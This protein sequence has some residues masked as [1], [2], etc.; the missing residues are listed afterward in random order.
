VLESSGLGY[1][2]QDTLK[3]GPCVFASFRSLL[4]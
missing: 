3:S 1:T 2:S 4:E